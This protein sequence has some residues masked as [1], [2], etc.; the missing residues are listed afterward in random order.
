MP[1][2]RIVNGVTAHVFLAYE[3][4]LSQIL[5]VLGNRIS[6][7]VTFFL[8][9]QVHY[10]NSYSDQFMF[11][12]QSTRQDNKITSQQTKDRTIEDTLYA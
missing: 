1:Q 9:Q 11:Q 7:H 2:H 8:L 5:I 6:I 12:Q 4:N 10:N 3:Y